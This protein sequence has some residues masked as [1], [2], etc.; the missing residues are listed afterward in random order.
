MGKRADERVR[1]MTTAEFLRQA[2]GQENGPRHEL[3]DGHYLIVDA[4]H[5]AVIHH[6]PGEEPDTIATRVVHAG[7]LPPR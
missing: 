3:V 1:R 2:A 4:A 7:E 5:R 6:V